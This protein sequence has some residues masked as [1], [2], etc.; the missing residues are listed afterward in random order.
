MPGRGLGPLLG[1]CGCGKITGVRH[2][3]DIPLNSRC[4]CPQQGVTTVNRGSLPST[5]G[6]HR[7]QEVTA[8][9]RGSPT[10]KGVHCRPRGSPLSTGVRRRQQG[11]IAVKRRV[12]SAHSGQCRPQGAVY[13][14]PCRHQG[15]GNTAKRAYRRQQGLTRVSQCPSAAADVNKLLT[16]RPLQRSPPHFSPQLVGRVWM[17][18]NIR[19]SG[20]GCYSSNEKS[21]HEAGC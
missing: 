6:H 2:R 9:N 13:M 18:I 5:G 3:Q 14:S 12:T 4:H 19:Q 11:V 7:E 8:V 15:L 21:V 20:S 10:S 16:R 1:G 17:Y